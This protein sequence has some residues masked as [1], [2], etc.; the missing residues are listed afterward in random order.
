MPATYNKDNPA[1]G[2]SQKLTGFGG[3]L[4]CISQLPLLRP[5]SFGANVL[6]TPRPSNWVVIFCLPWV[7]DCPSKEELRQVQAI[8]GKNVVVGLLN[9]ALERASCED[10]NLQGPQARF[11]PRG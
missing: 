9:C 2:L 10:M 1:L 3:F 4:I 11:Y 7:T 5:F 6:T 8:A